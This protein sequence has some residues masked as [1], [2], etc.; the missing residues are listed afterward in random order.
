MQKCGPGL[1]PQGSG[2]GDNSLFPESPTRCALP[3]ASL[4]V[5]S[6]QISV[7]Q[8]PWGKQLTENISAELCTC[9]VEAERTKPGNSTCTRP[10]RLIFRLAKVCKPK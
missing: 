5:L 3:A 7:F 6:V 2:A 4:C 9:G 8:S 10:Q 1:C